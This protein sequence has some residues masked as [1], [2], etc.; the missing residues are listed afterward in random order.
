MYACD[1]CRLPQALQ[2]LTKALQ[3]KDPP[4]ALQQPTKAAVEKLTNQLTSAAKQ[5]VKTPQQPFNSPTACAYFFDG[6]A[7]CFM[8][9]YAARVAAGARNRVKFWSDVY[10]QQL[11]DCTWDMAVAVN[12]VKPP[13]KILC[14]PQCL[15]HFAKMLLQLPPGSVMVARNLVRM[16]VPMLGLPKVQQ[17]LVGLGLVDNIAGRLRFAPR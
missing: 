17:Q 12:K 9:A 3:A 11:C 6:I 1:V 8:A 14:Q 10:V 15:Q 16:M 2:A 13:P 4:S 5:A 7:A